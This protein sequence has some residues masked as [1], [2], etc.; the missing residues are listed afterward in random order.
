[1]GFKLAIHFWPISVSAAASL[2]VELQ[3]G[4]QS[5]CYLELLVKYPFCVCLHC[6]ARC[7]LVGMFCLFFIHFIVRDVSLWKPWL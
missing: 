2:P 7:V 5:K 1:M 3:P 6:N 4:K